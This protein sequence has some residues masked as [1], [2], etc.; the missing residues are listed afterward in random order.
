M[1][2]LAQRIQRFLV[3]EDGPTVVEYAVMLVLIV[4]VCVT[5]IGVVGSKTN[6]TFE[7]MANSVAWTAS[8]S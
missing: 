4:T 7:T 8:G 1:K 6:T 2:P 3:S 5:A